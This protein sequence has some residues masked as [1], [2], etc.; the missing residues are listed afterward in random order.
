MSNDIYQLVYCSRKTIDESSGTDLDT[1]VL[2]ILDASRRNNAHD[3][4]TG[5]LL[6][7]ADSFAQ[8]LEGPLPA[9]EKTFERIQQDPRHGD[10]VIL[11]VMRADRRDF[12]E[13][14]MAYAGKLAPS[15]GAERTLSSA[16]AAG[17]QDGAEAVLSTLRSLVHREE[18]WA[19]AN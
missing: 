17:G 2:N 15:S 13:W 18:E 7:G 1:E 14:S 10:V 9:V 16:R 11:Q 12:A 5:A 3:G 4:V 8:V 19:A 6:F